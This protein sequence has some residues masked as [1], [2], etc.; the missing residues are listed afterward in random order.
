MA[1]KYNM[2]AGEI[3]PSPEVLKAKYAAKDNS[4]KIFGETMEPNPRTDR[5][6]RWKPKQ[7]LIDPNVPKKTIFDLAKEE[8]ENPNG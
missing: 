4:E 3:P 6:A 2:L 1:I 7:S 8:M 5:A